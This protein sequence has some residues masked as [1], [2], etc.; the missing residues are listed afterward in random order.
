MGKSR[1][2]AEGCRVA[3]SVLLLSAARK[4]VEI[5]VLSFTLN[6]SDFSSSIG[7]LGDELAGGA[8]CD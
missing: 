7:L 5:G 3:S 1:L 4:D 2:A 8:G 6:L